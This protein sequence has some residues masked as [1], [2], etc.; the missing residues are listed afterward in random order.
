MGID[1]LWMI[2]VSYAHPNGKKKIMARIRAGK[3]ASVKKVEDY[4]VSSVCIP[5]S[6]R[7]FVLEQAK[8]PFPG[9][10]RPKGIS[11]YVCELIVADKRRIEAQRD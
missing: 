8:E 10:V 4:I 2:V 7:S 5:K 1:R 11:G 3:K 6:L 9:T